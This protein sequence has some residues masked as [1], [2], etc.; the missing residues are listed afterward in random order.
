VPDSPLEVGSLA[1]E[2]S[3]LEEDSLEAEDSLL[4]EDS[5]EAASE[6]W[7]LLASDSPATS[8]PLACVLALCAVGD[9]VPAWDSPVPAAASLA[10][11]FG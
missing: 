3:P 11:A 9:S 2:D 1:E 6:L 7:P 5:P 8:P 4:E 10:V